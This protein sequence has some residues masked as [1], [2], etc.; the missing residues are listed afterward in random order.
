MSCGI[1]TGDGDHIGDTDEM[2]VRKLAEIQR[3][4]ESS[5]QPAYMFLKGQ[6]VT[7]AA[8]GDAARHTAQ[9]PAQVS[10]LGTYHHVRGDKMNEY[11]DIRA[12]LLSSTKAKVITALA[13]SFVPG[14][15]SVKALACGDTKEAS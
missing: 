6:G 2:V 13:A 9:A 5:Y 1:D 11:E 3:L 15:S 10:G 14:M 8:A 12:T 4:R 7:T